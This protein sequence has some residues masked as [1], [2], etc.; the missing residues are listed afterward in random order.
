MTDA[1]E[2]SALIDLARETF[3][4]RTSIRREEMRDFLAVLAARGF[5]LSADGYAP[6][7]HSPAAW[8]AACEGI[9]TISLIDPA[10]DA[11]APAS[12]N[13]GS[14]RYDQPGQMYLGFMVTLMFAPE[15]LCD[16]PYDQIGQLRRH[17][18]RLFVVKR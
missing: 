13:Q 8:A 1:H 4:S 7:D 6:G 18:H 3:A 9:T 14:I 10:A 11:G 16:E 17:C 15:A 5:D 2:M 12:I